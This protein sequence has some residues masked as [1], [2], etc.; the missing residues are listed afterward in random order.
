MASESTTPPLTASAENTSIDF[1]NYDLTI[2]QIC[3]EHMNDGDKCMVINVCS[4]IFHRSCIESSLATSC[5]CPICKQ[6]C[7]PSDLKEFTMQAKI[8]HVNRPSSKNRG[9]GAMT[10]HHN[11]RSSV[12]RNLATGYKPQTNLNSTDYITFSPNKNTNSSASNQR[13]AAPSNLIATESDPIDQRT[14]A[15]SDGNATAINYDE[16]GRFIEEK[17]NQFFQNLK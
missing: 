9:R 12:Q 5:E 11:T 14:T 6:T 3:N 17:L 8:T 15:A 7:Q 13:I 2:C 1:S 10:K 16:I 4:H